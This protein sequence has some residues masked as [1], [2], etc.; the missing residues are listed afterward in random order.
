MAN[1][2]TR[3]SYIVGGPRGMRFNPPGLT[4]VSLKTAPLLRKNEPPSPTWPGPTRFSTGTQGS[5]SWDFKFKVRSACRGPVRE[6]V[7]CYHHLGP[8]AATA[9]V[10]TQWVKT[11]L[12]ETGFPPPPSL[13]VT[14]YEPVTVLSTQIRTYAG[15]ATG[16]QRR[17]CRQGTGYIAGGRGGWGGEI[18]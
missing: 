6:V 11:G 15:S 5:K 17:A 9:S 8:T 10:G 4:T 3:Y 18:L 1:N 16:T 12:S 2:F 13:Y 14:I 7:P